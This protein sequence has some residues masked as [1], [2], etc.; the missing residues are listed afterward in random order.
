[1]PGVTRQTDIRGLTPKQ[2][3]DVVTDYEAYPRYFTDFTRV[4]IHR[5]DGDAWDVEFVAKVVK[6]VSYTLNIV[7]DPD[8]LTTRWTFIRGTLVTESKGGWTFIE[9]PTGAHI[10]YEAEIEVNAPL[11]GFIK[12][13]IQDAILNR[14]IAS[15]FTQLER[16]AR[17]RG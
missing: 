4:V 1:M 2:L 16:E 13:K 5:K 15:M 12:K 6:E 9:T 14:S 17:R 10:D 7:H 8:A 3:Y 11:P